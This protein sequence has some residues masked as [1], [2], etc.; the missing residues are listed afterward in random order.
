MEPFKLTTETRA[1]TG[2]GAARRMRARGLVP[3]VFY[4][5]AAQ[6]ALLAIDPKLLAHALS[7]PLRRN[8][9]LQLEVGGQSQ[10]AMF[11]EVQLHPV[12]RA[13]LHLDLYKVTLDQ[14]VHANVPF[15][16]EGR[17]KGVIAGGELNVVYRE[18]PVRA[19]PATIPAAITVDVTNV[20][21]GDSVRAKD[22]QLPEGVEVAFEP[23]RSLVTCAEPRKPPPEEEAAGGAPAAAAETPAAA[24]PAA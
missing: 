2:K 13:V 9:L 16:T 18:L 4:G 21:L 24:T 22:L 12:T 23:E 8:V 20:A 14:R 10:L 11:K 5:R 7:T 15:L 19:T 17:A 3:A 1:E 6:P